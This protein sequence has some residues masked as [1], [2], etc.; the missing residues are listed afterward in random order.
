MSDKPGTP[1][2][3]KDRLAKL[4]AETRQKNYSDKA[5]PGAN[6]RSAI[7]LAQ[8]QHYLSGLCA[9]YA[10]DAAAKTFWFTKNHDPQQ[11]R[12]WLFILKIFNTPQIELAGE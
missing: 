7:D 4:S 12:L 10:H 1:E 8:R 2:W 11:K 9:I 3:W 5:I 6:N